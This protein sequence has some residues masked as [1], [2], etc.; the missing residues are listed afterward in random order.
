MIH[1]FIVISILVN[2]VS[3]DE[4]KRCDNWPDAKPLGIFEEL[5][6]EHRIPDGVYQGTID[7]L[8]IIERIMENWGIYGS[9]RKI[10]SI[11]DYME[12]AGL[13][14]VSEVDSYPEKEMF[15]QDS[16]S[17]WFVVADNSTLISYFPHPEMCMYNTRM[18]TLKSK[19]SEEKRWKVWKN[20]GYQDDADFY[21]DLSFGSC[22]A[23]LGFICIIMVLKQY[24]QISHDN[25]VD[26][27][28]PPKY[29]KRIEESFAT[30]EFKRS[31]ARFPTGEEEFSL[32]VANN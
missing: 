15:S 1:L 12:A 2:F 11:T 32:I 31:H 28:P 7:T 10:H 30:H 20:W 14:K 17:F 9:N 3:C 5:D 23:I 27:D 19:T 22:L 21:A 8:T 13:Q 26:D 6:G 29:S 24:V 16:E 18:E 25:D 4:Q